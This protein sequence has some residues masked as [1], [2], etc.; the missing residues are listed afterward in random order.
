[1]LSCEI[2]KVMT[3]FLL[4]RMVPHILSMC[5]WDTAGTCN[6]TLKHWTGG[7]SQEPGISSDKH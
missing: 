1:M 5:D 3:N 2:M 4:I 6:P 7:T